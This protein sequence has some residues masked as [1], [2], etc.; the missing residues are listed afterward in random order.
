MTAAELH[1]HLTNSHPDK[2]Q[3]CK[4]LTCPIIWPLCRMSIS[5]LPM[6]HPLSSIEYS[7]L[8][9]PGNLACTARCMVHSS[10]L[11][12]ATTDES[13]IWPPLQITH[14]LFIL[15]NC[16]RHH[17]GKSC[18]LCNHNQAKWGLRFASHHL[19][20]R[21]ILDWHAVQKQTRQALRA[22][23]L[24]H[25]QSVCVLS[26]LYLNLCTTSSGRCSRCRLCTCCS[27]SCGC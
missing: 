2:I 1:K 14:L 11:T 25:V 15:I 24:D 16:S 23:T 21:T 12:L 19:G 27:N 4:E 8:S 5:R 22:W 20:L 9:L 26:V 7:T 3:K 6:I 18:V 17:S 10:L 13:V